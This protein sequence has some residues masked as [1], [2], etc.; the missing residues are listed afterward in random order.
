MALDRVKSSR[1]HV[2]Y[3]AWR[4]NYNSVS[5]LYTGHIYKKYNFMYVTM[6]DFNSLKFVDRV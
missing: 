1:D 6:A 2:G 5:L 3:H 4:S